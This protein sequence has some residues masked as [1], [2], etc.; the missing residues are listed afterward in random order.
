MKSL[1]KIS[2]VIPSYNK[3]KYIQQTLESIFS[4]KYPNLEVIIKDGGSVDGSV[5]IIRKFAKKYPTK[6]K[7]V[8][9]KDKGQVDA[10]NKGLK[11]ATG[12]ILTFIN[13]DD[14]YKEGA[15]I[16]VGKM[17]KKEPAILWAAGKGDIIDRKGKV[18]SGP[19][20]FY[21]NL[22]LRINKYPF[23]LV[24]NYFV[25]ASVFI[26]KSAYI[27][28]GPFGHI[29]TI[30]MEYDLWLKLGAIQM[31]KIENKYLASF[32]LTDENL[33]STQYKKIL[34]KDYEI[35]KEHTNN[36][37]TLFL[38]KLHNIARIAFVKL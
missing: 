15:L 12:D 6:I 16:K 3:V 32:R 5:E 28:Y 27:K 7:W 21:K 23:L 13:A 9:K 17:F 34:K 18:K 31:P 20:S 10:I 8:S 36:Y 14:L 2:I 22:L 37:I 38:H 25:Q 19:V 35:A 1:P 33:S 4:Q 26:N 24:V 30:V 11:Q 29:G